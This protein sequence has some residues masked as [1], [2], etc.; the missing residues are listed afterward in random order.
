MDHRIWAAFQNNGPHRIGGFGPR[1][2]N[3]AWLKKENMMVEVLRTKY[4]EK[5]VL[6]AARTAVFRTPNSDSA[7][8]EPDSSKNPIG[9]AFIR[10]LQ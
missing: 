5:E 10:I 7:L 6:M 1:Q 2:E 3:S 8:P 4:S 9:G